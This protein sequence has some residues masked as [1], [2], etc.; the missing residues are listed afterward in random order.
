MKVDFNN[1]RRQ[2]CLSYDALV[3]K[4]N[5]ALLTDDQWAR[6][7]GSMHGQDM[8][9]KGYVLID[10][11]ELQRDLDNLKVQI[12][13]IALCFEQDNPDCADVYPDTPLLDFNPEL[14]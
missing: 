5:A 7:N 9:I 11:E 13:S 14:E 4:L 8:N 10:A 12:G 2:A 6:P 3:G 1:L